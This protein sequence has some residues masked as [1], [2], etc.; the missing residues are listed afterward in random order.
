MDIHQNAR[1]TPYNRAELVRRVVQEGQSPTAVAAAFGLSAKTVRK[2]V[3][4]FQAEGEAGLLDRSS[5]PHRLHRPT[6]AATAA[7]IEALRRQRMT[8]QQ[9]AQQT[10][11]SPATVSRV[12]QR[13]G[14]SSLKALEPAEPVRRYECDS[15]GDLTHID[16]KK[17]GQFTRTGQSSRRGVGWEFVHV[18][19]DDASRLAFSQ[20]T[21]P[22]EL[23]HIIRKGQAKWGRKAQ[24]S[25][26]AA[27][28]AN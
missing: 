5:R 19:I 28:R 21:Q 15:P 22:I 14:L 6:P 20:I 17:L 27:L 13:L 18:G 9:I 11:V 16:I 12:L 7:R 1:T 25:L 4:R 2:W 8:G 23:V 26:A 3:A 10:G 24:R